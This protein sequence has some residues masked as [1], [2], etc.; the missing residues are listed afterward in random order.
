MMQNVKTLKKIINVLIQNYSGRKIRLI[1]LFLKTLYIFGVIKTFA[2]N[3]I[4]L[5]RG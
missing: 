3:S 1:Y 2:E 5:E 4:K